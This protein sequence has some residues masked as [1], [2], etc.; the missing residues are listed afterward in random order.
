MDKSQLKIALVSL[1]KDAEKEPPLGLVYLATYLRDVVGLEQKN[2]R[3]FD[4]NYFDIEKEISLFKPHIVGITSMAIDY[5]KATQFASNL[6]QKNNPPIILG[7]VHISTLPESFRKC[8]DIGVI[9]EGEKTFEELI[10]L[11][12]KKEEFQNKDLTKV[13]S[14]VY[15]TDDKIKKTKLR[16]PLELD[17]LP[18]PDFDFVHKNYFYFLYPNLNFLYYLL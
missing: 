17:S 8:F 14:I 11:Y 12:L 5:E 18:L 13:K 2:I 4:R 16:V 9:G 10:K 3:I 15:F 1:Q 7:G 6:K